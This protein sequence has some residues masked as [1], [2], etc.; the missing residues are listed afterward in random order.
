MSKLKG[1]RPSQEVIQDFSNKC[2]EL[3]GAVLRLEQLPQDI[4]KIKSRL[5]ELQLELNEAKRQETALHIIDKEATS[6]LESMQ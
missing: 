1:C 4:T 6:A 2:A 3:G 5:S